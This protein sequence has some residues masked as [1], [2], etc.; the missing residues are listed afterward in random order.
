MLLLINGILLV[1]CLL[2]NCVGYYNRNVT[3]TTLSSTTTNL[4]Q[5]TLN[6]FAKFQNNYLVVYLCMTFSDWLQGAYVYVLYES[7]GYEIETI[8]RLFI[9]GFFS[10]MIFGTIIGSLSDKLGRKKICLTFVVLYALACLTKHS[11]NL[12]VLMIGRFFSGIATSILSSVFESWMIYEHNNAKFDPSWI[13]DTFYQQTFANGIIAILSGFVS[14]FLYDIIG[15]PVAPFDCAIIFL[16]I[17]GAI[18]YYNWNENYGDTTGDWK[19]NFIRGYEVIRT[20]KKVLCVAISQSFFEAAM[21]IFVLMWTPTLQQA[22]WDGVK[23]LDIGYVFAAFMISVMIGS[24]IFKIFYSNASSQKSFTNASR[25][26][27][28]EFILLIVFITA[29]VSFIIPIFF[30]SFTPILLSFLVFEACVGVF[31]PAISTMKSMYIPEDV[32]STV[33]NY[34]RIP[35][36]FLVVLS[37]Y[38]VNSISQFEVCCGL[39]LVSVTSQYYLFKY[40]MADDTKPNF[41]SQDNV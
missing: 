4:T 2:L 13:G 21:Y 10:S 3:T 18:I 37:L 36:N 30:S 26:S 8:S 32:R 38:Y 7:Y 35:T 5:S 39:L 23:Q 19:K 40:H 29:I 34:I 27:S 28:V 1:I 6:T 25:F 15:S 41:T 12:V 20:D 9:F 14:N 33:M 11:S 16:V 17:G 31:W 22:Y 24:S